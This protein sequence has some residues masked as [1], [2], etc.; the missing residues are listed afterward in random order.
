MTGVRKTRRS[1]RARA[2]DFDFRRAARVAV[3]P[4]INGYVRLWRNGEASLWKMP[5]LEDSDELEELLCSGA[6]SVDRFAPAHHRESADFDP[7]SKV[8]CVAK[9]IAFSHRGGAT[10]GSGVFIT[11]VP[12]AEATQDKPG[13]SRDGSGWDEVEKF[14]A[15]AAEGAQTRGEV[16]VV[17]PGPNPHFNGPAVLLS[18]S[19]TNAW[20][21]SVISASPPPTCGKWGEAASE[22][23]RTTLVATLSPEARWEAASLTVD[24]LREWGVAPF[25][26][27]IAF[28]VP[29][30]LITRPA[31]DEDW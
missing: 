26:V 25:D 12:V 14:I 6:V 10:L 19:T 31:P 18:T 4:T 22:P 9:T 24:A 17:G 23:D 2:E 1:E 3:G 15:R 30:E 27:G 13:A 21:Y 11:L 7:G 5:I 29:I 20:T 16:V 8:L 28:I